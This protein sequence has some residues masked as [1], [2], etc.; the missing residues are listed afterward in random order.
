MN[1]QKEFGYFSKFVIVGVLATLVDFLVLNLLQ[2]TLLPPEGV[3]TVFNVLVASSIS[4]CVGIF[5]SFTINRLW[6]YQQTQRQIVQQLMQFFTVYLL[7]L[8]IRVIV[9]RLVYPVWREF[10]LSTMTDWTELS[11]NQL[12]S[13]L[14]QGTAIGVTLFWNFAANRLWTFGDISSAPEP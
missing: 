2:I 1:F 6:I 4:Y 9:I 3:M 13:N 14:A 11:I 7:A 10:T 8:L 12:A 5:F